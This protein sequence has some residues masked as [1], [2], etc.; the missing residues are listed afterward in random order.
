[1]LGLSVAILAITQKDLG[2]SV[3][4][5]FTMLALL[6]LSGRSKKF[7]ISIATFATAV[8]TLLIAVA[9][10]RILRLK[11][12]WVGIQDSILSLLPQ[13]IAT[14]LKV[15]DST[16]S[17]PIVN[18]R[19]AFENGGLFGQGLGSGQYK[20]G[21]ISEVQTDFIMAGLGEEIGFIGILIILLLFAYIIYI[22]LKIGSQLK[23]I[24][25]R[26]F[27]YGVAIVLFLSLAINLYGVTG[28]IPEKGIAVPILS[29]GGSQL[30]ATAVAIGMVL[31]LARR[32]KE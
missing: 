6:F 14:A 20:L 9:P 5:L 19:S 21:F 11:G 28:I 10:H 16:E 8:V 3:V 12:W 1:M 29:Y 25:E 24:H 31:M 7:F 30:V 18:A 27:S 23:S 22:I 2:Q 32:I 17:L 4:L 15:T 26:Y 13:S